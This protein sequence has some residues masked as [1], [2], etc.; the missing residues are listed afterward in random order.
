M[1]LSSYFRLW[2]YNHPVVIPFLILGVIL[3][4]GAILVLRNEV[5]ATYT[6]HFGTVCCLSDSYF[7]LSERAPPLR[8]MYV[9]LDNGARVEVPLGP[10]KSLALF[11][12]DA[13][14]LVRQTHKAVGPYARYVAIRFASDGDS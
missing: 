3:A 9:D 2:S 4:A 6:D 10:G 1:S 14:V 12:P 11:Q 5:R 13:R 8:M 7:V